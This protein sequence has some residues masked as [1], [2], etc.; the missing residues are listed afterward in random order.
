TWA[1]GHPAHPAVAAGAPDIAVADVTADLASLQS[2][3][4]ANGGNRADGQPGYRA[5]VDFVKQQAQAAGYTVSEQEFSTSRGTSY[6][7]VAELPGTDPS[8]V[9]MVGA[10]LD[11]VSAGPGIN[12]DGSGSASILE[13]AKA[14]AAA[15]PQPDVTV[16]FAWWGG[17]EL[18]LLGSEHYVD[19]LPGAEL[20]KITS[21]LNF[22]MT[23][24]PNPGYFVYDDDSNLDAL[25]TTYFDGLG[26]A[27][28]PETEGDGRS[29]HA[30]FKDAGIPVGGLFSGADYIKTAEQA[31]NW[32]GTEGEA[33]DPCYHESCDTAD[34]IDATALDHNADAISY[35]VWTLTGP[36]T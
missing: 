35:A 24:S 1:G 10:H 25:F 18:G 3:A 6:N 26:I 22:D 27:T 12:D 36:A 14:F 16:R 34:N 11:S 30:P 17:E 2:I 20:G 5:S 15:R 32:G 28:E 4:D 21:Y 23:G 8:K 13:V 33:F 9:V 19:S 29:D 7:V 31:Q